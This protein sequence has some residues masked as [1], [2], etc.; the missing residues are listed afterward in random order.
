MVV[1]KL[2]TPHKT[3]IR[4]HGVS[5]DG[6]RNDVV[7]PVPSSTPKY[8]KLIFPSSQVGCPQGIK[9]GL[10]EWEY[11]KRNGPADSEL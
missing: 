6:I 4:L 2:L 10:W 3:K 7:R 8:L 9:L 11:W 1:L 5:T